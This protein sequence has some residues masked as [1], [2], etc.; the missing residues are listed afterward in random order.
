MS[1]NPVVTRVHS[2]AMHVCVPEEWSDDRVKAFADRKNPCD[3]PSGWTVCK[4]G[5]VALAGAPER[6][7]CKGREGYVHMVL[8]A[9]PHPN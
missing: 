1:S 5:E 9:S 8:E 2:F 4:E 3:A 6:A 7:P